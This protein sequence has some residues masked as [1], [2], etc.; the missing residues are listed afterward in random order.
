LLLTMETMPHRLDQCGRDAEYNN[1]QG[2]KQIGENGEPKSFEYL[3]TSWLGCKL[4]GL[5]P[6]G[7]N[8]AQ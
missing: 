7:D 3:L 1:D 8:P 5:G 4:M 6:C 2:A